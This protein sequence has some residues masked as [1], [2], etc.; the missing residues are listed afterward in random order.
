[1]RLNHFIFQY[2]GQI[3]NGVSL[4][5]LWSK[6]LTYVTWFASECDIYILGF[7]Q[8]VKHFV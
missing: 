3:Q 1:M 6:L 2:G 4:H 5:G 8:F 7:L